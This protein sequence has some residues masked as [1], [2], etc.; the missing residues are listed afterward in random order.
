MPHLL[1]PPVS[2]Y[3]ACICSTTK[4]SRRIVWI[5]EISLHIKTNSV[6]Y[7]VWYFVHLFHYTRVLLIEWSGFL[8]FA[9]SFSVFSSPSCSSSVFSELMPLLVPCSAIGCS[10]CAHLVPLSTSTTRFLN[11]LYP[12]ELTPR[13]WINE[14]NGSPGTL[15]VIFRRGGGVSESGSE[16]GFWTITLKSSGSHFSDP[17]HN[18]CSLFSCRCLSPLQSRCC[19]NI[20]L[21]F[22]DSSQWPAVY[23]RPEKVRN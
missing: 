17:Y 9:A 6:V 20:L 22:D 14:L 1:Y 5:K 18:R 16:N 19:Q 8:W 13:D 15:R 12:V 3:S 11:F 7:S 4:T 23:K 10:C 21:Y 2:W